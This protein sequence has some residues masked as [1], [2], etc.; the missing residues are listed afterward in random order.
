MKLLAIDTSTEACSAALL[1]DGD[2]CEVFELAPREHTQRILPMVDTLLANGETTL[3]QLDAL[4]FGRGPGSFTGVR[5]A[6]GVI[7]GIAFGAD[8][9]V[10]PVSSLAAMAQG[11]YR[12]T[13][14][15]KLIVAI[16]ARIHEVYWGVYTI[17]NQIAVL[18]GRELVCKPEAVPVPSMANCVGIGSGW[19]SYGDQLHERLGQ[20]ITMAKG[21]VYP[22]AQDVATLGAADFEHGKYLIPERALP[23]YL[24]DDV[25]VKPRKING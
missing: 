20:T 5:I 9:P 8:L 10:I 11:G 3:N 14:S 16:D 4:V 15:T 17:D 7:Q 19:A 25:V 12:E 22:H 6:A 21:D 23:V 2:V 24:R 13:G 1:V 18:T